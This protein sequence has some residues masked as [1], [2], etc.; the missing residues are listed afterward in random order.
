MYSISRTRNDPLALPPITSPLLLF[1]CLPRPTFPVCSAAFSSLL[2]FSDLSPSSFN[3]SL[4]SYLHCDVTPP[5]KKKTCFPDSAVHTEAPFIPSCFLRFT[6]FFFFFTQE[7]KYLSPASV[8]HQPAAASESFIYVRR[9]LLWVELP[10][11]MPAR[12]ATREQRRKMQACCF[13]SSIYM[14]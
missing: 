8:C 10:Q 11:N 6:S 2:L 1:L 5:Q 14:S 9:L 7:H 12:H 13:F 4:L 3:S